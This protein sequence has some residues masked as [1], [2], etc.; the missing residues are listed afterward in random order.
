MKAMEIFEVYVKPGDDWKMLASFESEPEALHYVKQLVARRKVSWRIIRDRYDPVAEMFKG[1]R[2][3]H[4]QIVQGAAADVKGPA[5]K[6]REMERLVEER[7]KRAQNGTLGSVSGR[8]GGDEQEGSLFERF[9]MM[10]K[11]EAREQKGS[12]GSGVAPGVAPG[13]TPVNSPAAAGGTGASR[14]AP[15]RA[16]ST[17]I[18][19]TPQGVDESIKP[20]AAGVQTGAQTGA[21]TKGAPIGPPRR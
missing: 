16:T 1:R 15:A 13:V 19:P 10:R 17:P 14:A 2:I 21:Q 4:E 12:L 8:G 18:G 3:L 9:V 20:N 5:A 7:H 6:A 11:Q